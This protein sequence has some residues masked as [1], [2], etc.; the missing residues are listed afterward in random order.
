MV[1]FLFLPHPWILTKI[2]LYILTLLWLQIIWV[3]SSAD[4]VN[5]SGVTSTESGSSVSPNVTSNPCLKDASQRFIFTH[6]WMVMAANH[7]MAVRLSGLGGKWGRKLQS[8]GA[9]VTQAFHSSS[10][11]WTDWVNTQGLS[12]T[13]KQW[14]VGFMRAVVTSVTYLRR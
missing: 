5:H 2:I 12:G 11:L 3:E 9:G 10:S 1:D 6:L 4:T 8:E 7:H 14:L 13:G